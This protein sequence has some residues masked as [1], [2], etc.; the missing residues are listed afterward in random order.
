MTG[1]EFAF[2]AL[3][4]ML[5][6]ASGAAAAFV[7][8]SRPPSREVRLTIARDSVPRRAST[9]SDDAILARSSDAAPGGPGDRRQTDPET[10]FGGVD[11][12]VGGSQTVL[13][14]TRRS[15]QATVDTRTPVPSSPSSAPVAVSIEPE[16]DRA[17]AYLR[18][19]RSTRPLV[20]RIL[21]GDHRAM[22]TALD[23][24][25]GEDGPTR[26]TWEGL[27]SGLVEALDQRAI[28][29]GYLDFPM[30][31]P[32]WGTFNGEQ[33]R[34]IAAALVSMGFRFDGREGWE[35]GRAPSYRQLS[36]AVSEIGIDTRRVRTWPNTLEIGELYRGVRP[37]PEDAIVDYAPTL[38]PRALRDLLGSRGEPFDDLWLT[39]EPVR[40]VLLELEPVAVS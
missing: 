3:G 4:L 20:E 34:R 36:S 14:S 24:I 11:R 15:G 39:W 12:R 21:R 29:L 8:R 28:D 33:C 2:L 38:E 18:A 10:G 22:L 31:A 27:L 9:L 16:P 26:R 7:F 13:S 19:G 6:A 30:G 1:S 32:F 17:L 5:G 40:Q 35:D 37:A 23:E 25:A